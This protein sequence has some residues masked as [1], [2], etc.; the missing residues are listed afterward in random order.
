MRRHSPGGRD[1]HEVWV[2]APEGDSTR[3]VTK[4]LHEAPFDRPVAG[5]AHAA[6]AGTVA[7]QRPGR[8]DVVAAAA[9]HRPG[10]AARGRALRRAHGPRRATRVG[11]RAVRAREADGTRPGRLL[12]EP[13]C[14]GGAVLAVGV[15]RRRRGHRAGA[16]HDDTGDGHG[17]RPATPNRRSSMPPPRVLV[18]A[19]LVVLLGLGLLGAAGVAA[20]SLRGPLPV[21]PGTDLR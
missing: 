5:E 9:R 20:A 11:R 7:A 8:P 1:A 13:L 6:G 2:W 17:R 14:L 21:P 15:H 12:V 4:A 10:R 18:A 16:G 3:A 19:A